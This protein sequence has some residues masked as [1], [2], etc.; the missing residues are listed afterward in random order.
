MTVALNT[1]YVPVS[2]AEKS[3]EKGETTYRTLEIS[4]CEVANLQLLA[5]VCAIGGDN[6]LDGLQERLHVELDADLHDCGHRLEEA[7][8]VADLLL[9]VDDQLDAL[10]QDVL[11]LGLFAIQSQQK[12]SMMIGLRRSVG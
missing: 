8:Q 10:D 9:Q 3:K 2:M 1:C 5:R 7:Y 4:E 12:T 11:D 6:G